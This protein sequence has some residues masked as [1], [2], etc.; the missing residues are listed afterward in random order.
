MNNSERIKSI[1]R[2]GKTA[3]GQREL[4]KHLEGHHLTSRQAVY[5]HCYDRM[6]FYADGKNDCCI[7]G[8][9]LYPFMHYNVNKIKRTSKRILTEAHKAI[10][11]S[12]RRRE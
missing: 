9:S 11:Q 12:A 5:A 7:P 10:M 8:C 2:T 6:G 3:R 1:R 4:I